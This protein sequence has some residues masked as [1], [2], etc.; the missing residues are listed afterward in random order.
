MRVGH[1][2]PARTWWESARVYPSSTET[3]SETNQIMYVSSTKSVVHEF[4]RLSAPSRAVASCCSPDHCVVEDPVID[5]SIDKCV[6]GVNTDGDESTKYPGLTADD[7]FTI[8][9]C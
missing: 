8:L 9:R 5:A 6:A 2:L 3:L 1:S 4:P 7:E